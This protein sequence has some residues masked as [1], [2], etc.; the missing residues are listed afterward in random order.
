MEEH[1]NILADAMLAKGKRASL[2]NL[3]TRP[4]LTFFKYYILKASFLDGR[5]GLIIAYKTTIGVLLK[6]SVLYG[7]EFTA[8]EMTPS[9]PK[10]HTPIARGD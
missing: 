8:S 3:L 7:R 2:L 1:A 4:A 5:F 10:G 6:Y 9:A